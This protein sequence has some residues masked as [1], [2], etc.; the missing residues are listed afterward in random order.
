[1][2]ASVWLG[3][4]ATMSSSSPAHLIRISFF[5]FACFFLSHSQ[6]GW[7][8]KC[9]PL[10]INGQCFCRRQRSSSHDSDSLSP[11]NQQEKLRKKKFC[12]RWKRQP[13]SQLNLP[14]QH[15][16]VWRSKRQCLSS[17][18]WCSV[19]TVLQPISSMSIFAQL[20]LM[21]L[22]SNT[23][24]PLE[25]RH[26]FVLIS[27]PSTSSSSNGSSSGHR[28]FSSHRFLNTRYNGSNWISYNYY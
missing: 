9:G 26:L 27:T 21:P 1:M 20:A 17:T 3:F 25:P 2:G 22:A 11:S 28:R 23:L 13:L 14:M 18:G 5:F 6:D 8:N 4:I 19:P 10:T 7:L 15:S 12:Y 16:A 24:R